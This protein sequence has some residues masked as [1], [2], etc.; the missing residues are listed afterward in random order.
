[1]RIHDVHKGTKRKKRKRVGRGPSSGWGKTAGRGHKGFHS[2]SGNSIPLYFEGGQMPLYR[3]V[4]Q[5]GF[6][7]ARFKKD[8]QTVNVSQLAAFEDGSTVGPAE[9][10]AKRILRKLTDDG[11]KILGNG[12]IT[13]K[14]TVKANAFSASARQKIEAAGGTVE[15]L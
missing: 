8:P 4:P 15:T 7:N 6:T 9:L 5:R 11:V 3:R 1:M 2:R 13:V 10:L 14:L 12:E